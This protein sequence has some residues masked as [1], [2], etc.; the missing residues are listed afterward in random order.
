MTVGII[1]GVAVDALADDEQAVMNRT[2]AASAMS[3]IFFMGCI[4]VMVLTF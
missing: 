4:S 1:S 3:N 2:K